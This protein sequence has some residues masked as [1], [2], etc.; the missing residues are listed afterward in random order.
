M[1]H[2]IVEGDG[3]SGMERNSANFERGPDVG[4]R[5]S[6]T[7]EKRDEPGSRAT[8]DVVLRLSRLGFPE[9]VYFESTGN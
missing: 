9:R 5:Q 8:A 1:L 6:S 7:T 3:S 4:C 2:Q